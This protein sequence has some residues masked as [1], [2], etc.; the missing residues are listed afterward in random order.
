MVKDAAQPSPSD[1]ARV[2]MASGSRNIGLTEPSSPKKGIGS[3]RCAQRLNRARP[4]PSEPVKADSL[5]QRMRD[6]RFTDLAVTTLNETEHALGHAGLDEGGMNGLGDDLAG[7]GWA[8][9]PFTTTGQP[10]ARA[11]AVSPPAV[12]KA[13]GKLDAP[14]T[15][16]GPIGRCI[17]R[18]SGRGAGFRSGRASSTRRSR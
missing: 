1:G 10:A 14:K 4:P 18:I 16:T 17:S 2:F 9:W 11:A 13:R 7:P 5:D 3:G 8:E 6:Q 15:A 12:E